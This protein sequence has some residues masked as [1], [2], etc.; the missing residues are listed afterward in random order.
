MNFKTLTS[1]IGGGEIEKIEGKLDL[2]Q[3]KLSQH[4]MW[5]FCSKLIHKHKYSLRYKGLGSY[6]LYFFVFMCVCVL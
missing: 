2:K 4:V 5:C 6:K 3:K 1:M